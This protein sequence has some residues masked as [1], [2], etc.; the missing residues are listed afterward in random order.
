M[1]MV[2]RMTDAE[3]ASPARASPARASPKGASAKK[4]TDDEEK[5]KASPQD[6]EKVKEKTKTTEEKEE[7][8]KEERMQREQAERADKKRA[9]EE[10]AKAE[11][12][13]KHAWSMMN[14][15]VRW[16]KVLKTL[17]K[18]SL[19]AANEKLPNQTPPQAPIVLKTA[20]ITKYVYDI[21]KHPTI[22]FKKWKRTKTNVSPEEHYYVAFRK[23]HDMLHAHFSV[24]RAVCFEFIELCIDAPSPSPSPAPAQT[25]SPPPSW[26]S[27]RIFSISAYVAQAFMRLP[28]EVFYWLLSIIRMIFEN[29]LV[30]YRFLFFCFVF[31]V[32]LKYVASVLVLFPVFAPYLP[33]IKV[34]QI[35]LNIILKILQTLLCYYR[36]VYS[37]E[38]V[39]YY[40]AGQNIM[41]FLFKPEMYA[42]ARSILEILAMTSSAGSAGSA[43]SATDKYKNNVL[44]SQLEPKLAAV[45]TAV[46]AWLQTSSDE[47]RTRVVKEY[48]AAQTMIDISVLYKSIFTN[49]EAGLKKILSADVNLVA[50]TALAKE[51]HA[52]YM[53]ELN[54]AHEKTSKDANIVLLTQLEPKLD[55]VHTA[56]LKWI[57]NETV[58]HKHKVNEEVLAAQTMIGNA[59][60]Y[61]DVFSSPQA[62][63]RKGDLLTKIMNSSTLPVAA[64]EKL[65]E[66]LHA[67]YRSEF[68]RAFAKYEE[69][70]KKQRDLRWKQTY[71]NLS[72]LTLSGL[73]MTLFNQLNAYA[74]T[75][76]SNDQIIR[77]LLVEVLQASELVKDIIARYIPVELLM[78]WTSVFYYSIIVDYIHVFFM[79]KFL[80]C[81]KNW[82][83]NLKNPTQLIYDDFGK[84]AYY[85][86]FMTLLEGK[87][88]VSY[89]D[90]LKVWS[91]GVADPVLSWFMGDKPTKLSAAN[92]ADYV[93]GVKNALDANEIDTAIKDSILN[94]LKID[95]QKAKTWF[96]YLK[97]LCRDKYPKLKMFLES[98]LSDVRSA[99]WNLCAL[100]LNLFFPGYMSYSNTFTYPFMVDLMKM[101]QQVLFTEF[102]TRAEEEDAYDE[103]LDAYEKCRGTD[104]AF[105]Y[106]GPRCTEEESNQAPRY[107]PIH[108]SGR[109]H[110][111]FPRPPEEDAGGAQSSQQFTW[112][113]P[114]TKLI[115]KTCNGDGGGG[116]NHLATICRLK[117]YTSHFMT[118]LLTQEFFRP[119]M[120][121][122]IYYPLLKKFTIWVNPSTQ[123]FW[124]TFEKV[125]YV[126]PVI[127]L[128]GKAAEAAVSPQVFN[129]K[130]L[131]FIGGVLQ[132]LM[133]DATIPRSPNPNPNANHA[134]ANPNANANESTAWDFL[135]PTSM[136][137]QKIIQFCINIVRQ[138]DFRKFQETKHLK[139]PEMQRIREKYDINQLLIM[140]ETRADQ[141]FSDADTK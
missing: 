15:K 83:V 120:A 60:L 131:F 74:K 39:A 100:F 8:E 66:D 125:E 80:E 110:T 128:A 97:K 141:E 77:T 52:K 68:L 54:L 2:V 64:K 123:T 17:M 91:L 138:D 4:K 7:E 13:S 85:Q 139:K 78:S 35:T 102:G 61:A 48:A 116:N 140:V 115:E 24:N 124:N 84:S 62:K 55:A 44:L 1:Q 107:A 95:E 133:K 58:E 18:K 71:A 57:R 132:I 70:E 88:K 33:Q 126:V 137:P 40:I 73:S 103:K 34:F 72:K 9:A 121:K 106:I 14:A 30:A 122:R 6:A 56:I 50:K 117:M 129:V 49:K 136:S 119:Y 118:V 20:F 87:K 135:S 113:V 11:A 46:M 109:Q 90:A 22:L 69:H 19:D 89:Q 79:D 98:L 104:H 134:H 42:V 81:K 37:S 26:K 51:M 108:P 53:N 111:A 36:Q 94:G 32:F 27:N 28:G 127:T 3:R 105:D 45:N 41:T 47:N 130:C 99:L 76:T 101:V 63:A 10:K 43:G 96:E 59:T 112:I 29:G 86:F 12:E 82:R 75:M 65:A 31:A 92:A 23:H 114:D 93:A 5:E 25:S 38:F 67:L 16:F 21:L